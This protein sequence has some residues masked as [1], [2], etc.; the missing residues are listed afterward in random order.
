MS[1][2]DDTVRVG[3]LGFGTVGQAVTKI[4][5][6]GHVPGVE[7]VQIFNRGIAVKRVD[8]V[9]STINWTENV[10]DVLAGE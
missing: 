2:S 6:E 4:L 10:D 7:L 8:W 5:C 9:P 3:L 1:R